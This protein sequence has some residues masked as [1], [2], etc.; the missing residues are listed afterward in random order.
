MPELVTSHHT[1]ILHVSP[2]A[3]LP[4]QAT[5]ISPRE[6]GEFNELAPTFLMEVQTNL[7]AEKTLS[8]HTLELMYRIELT[9]CSLFVISSPYYYFHYYHYYYNFLSP[10]RDTSTRKILMLMI[11][12][13]TQECQI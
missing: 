10:D 2:P 1:H 3:S 4:V 8:T 12:L 7:T 5:E 9:L 13:H 6:P 11:F